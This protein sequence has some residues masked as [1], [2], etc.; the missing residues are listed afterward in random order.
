M[1]EETAVERELVFQNLEFPMKK[2]RVRS[3][4]EILELVKKGNKE[5]YQEI[6][7]RYMKTAYYI[8]LGLVHNHQDALD[9]SQEA[10]VKAF[11]RIKSFNAERPFF[12]WFYQLMKNLCIDHLKRISRMKEVPLDGIQVLDE[13]K[14]DKEM[15]RVLWK[16][17][18]ELTFEQREVIILRYFRQFSYQEI[19][20]IIDKPLG[21]VMSSLYYAKK[22]LKE[23]VGRYLGFE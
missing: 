2:E 16:G 3:E 9:I 21:T 20:E 15:K 23:I 11:R 10:F 6:V 17:I 7:S 12:P 22:R 19:S 13:K 4:K 14:E 18:E 1:P 5:A 8:A